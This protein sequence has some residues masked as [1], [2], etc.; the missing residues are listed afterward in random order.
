MLKYFGSSFLIAG[1]GFVLAYFIGG[2]EAIWITFILSVLE[3]SLSFD[4][5]I[6]NAQVLK[7]MDEVWRRRFITWGMAIAVFGMRIVFPLLIVSIAI[8]I[9]PIQAFLLA[10]NAPDDYK[11]AL[12]SV[13]TSVMGYGGSF[14]M[15]VSLKF[16]IDHDKDIHWLDKI[17]IKLTKLGKIEAIQAAIT[18]TLVYFTSIIIKDLHGQEESS[19]FLIASIWGIITFILV[20]GLE[21]IIGVEDATTSIAKSGLAGFLYLELLDSSFSFDGVLAALSLTNNIF[22]IAIGLGVGALFVRSLTLLMVDKGTVDEFVYLEHGAFYAIFGLSCIMLV[23]TVYEIPESITGLLGAVFIVSSL[24]S[25][26]RAKQ[27][28]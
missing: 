11:H 27:S 3:V 28:S 17:E 4:N 10:L 12:E 14:L 8:G 20:D 13:H 23:N 5:A 18:L 24:I 9:S 7:G 15:L 1:I 2:Y 16:F 19:A 6:V 21:A 25:S 22:I 26:I